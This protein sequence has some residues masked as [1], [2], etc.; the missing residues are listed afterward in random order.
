MQLVAFIESQHLMTSSI[1]TQEL[2]QSPV[3]G[4]MARPR[5]GEESKVSGRIRGL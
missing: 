4:R 2:K 5:T 1:T 3:R